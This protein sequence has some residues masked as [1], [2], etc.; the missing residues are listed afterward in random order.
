MAKS[1]P[2][3][4]SQGFQELQYEILE[5]WTHWRREPFYHGHILEHGQRKET[6]KRQ[7]S[8]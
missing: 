2:P 3:P 8:N 5:I 1:N 4:V 7:Q 6:N